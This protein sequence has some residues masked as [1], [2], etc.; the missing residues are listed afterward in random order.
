MVP[1]N[2]FKWLKKGSLVEIIQ[3]NKVEINQLF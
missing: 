2:L 1:I 3:D